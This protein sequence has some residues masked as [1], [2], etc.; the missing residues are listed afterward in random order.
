MTEPSSKQLNSEAAYKIRTKLD[1]YFLALTFTILG[2]SVETARFGRTPA[3]DAAELIAWLFL[4]ISGM[5]GLRR[6]FRLPILY[7]AFSV[8]AGKQEAINELKKAKVEQGQTLAYVG[9][10]DATL[11]S[12]EVIAE[13]GHTVETIDTAI[14]RLNKQLNRRYRVQAGAFFIGMLALMVARGLAALVDLFGYKL[15]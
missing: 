7:D 8:K 15:R 3:T 10:V 9:P 5:G 1:F 4:F 12:D 6:L 13:L 11:P 2:F 14:K